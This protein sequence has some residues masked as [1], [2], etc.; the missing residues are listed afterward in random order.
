MSRIASASASPRYFSLNCGKLGL[1]RPVVMVPPARGRKGEMAE[2]AIPR[3]FNRLQVCLDRP[4]R[5]VS[6]VPELGEVGGRLIGSQP[7]GLGDG[8]GSARLEEPFPGPEPVLEA[9]DVDRPFRPD[10]VER[11]VREGGIEHRCGAEG[12][13]A[14]QSAA[15]GRL[16][17]LSEKGQVIVAATTRPPASLAS[18]IVCMPGPQPISRMSGSRDAGWIID[19]AFAV[20]ALSPGPCRGSPEWI[21]KKMF[22]RCSVYLNSVP[23]YSITYLGGVWTA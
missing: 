18:S 4:H 22:T 17:Q 20:E 9:H 8:D 15:S 13:S 1:D 12:D 19:Q 7:D 3:R 16:P 11:P 23:E 14:G 10:D 5:R 6:G 21:S 2:G